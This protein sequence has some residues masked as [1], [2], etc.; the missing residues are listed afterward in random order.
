MH[1]SDK[2]DAVAEI[3][4]EK[5]LNATSNFH[6]TLLGVLESCVR[7]TTPDKEHDYRIPEPSP[8]R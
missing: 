1:T 2:Y 4:H 6:K 7:E 5:R 8:S 3:L